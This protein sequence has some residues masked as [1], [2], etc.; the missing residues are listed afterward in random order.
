VTTK[1]SK[2]FTKNDVRLALAHRIAKH[3][4]PGQARPVDR[5]LLAKTAAR[6]QR[7]SEEVLRAMPCSPVKN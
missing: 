6:L 3:D 4:P 1:S 7:N 2:T 5:E